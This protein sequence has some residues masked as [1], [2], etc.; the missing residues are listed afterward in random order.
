ML[1]RSI[2]TGERLE[3]NLRAL[4]AVSIVTAALGLVL[5]VYDIAKGETI[6]TVAAF[7]TFLG[8]LGCGICAG[9]FKKREAAAVIPTVFCAIV[10]TIYTFFPAKLPC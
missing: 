8:G 4:V 6:M 3:A 2:Y 1:S 5:T 9:V 7:N 10:F